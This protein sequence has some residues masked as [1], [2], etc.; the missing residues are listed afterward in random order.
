MTAYEG[1][2][3][4]FRLQ[5]K[6]LKRGTTD[7]F[8]AR[9]LETL[10]AR[11]R[12]LC[13][14][15]ALAVTA[16]NRLVA[17]WIGTGI[18]VQWENKSMQRAWDEFYSNPNLDGFGSLLNTQALWAGGVFEVG[19][20]FDRMLISNKSNATIP[21]KLQSIAPEQLD[22]KYFKL[23]KIKNSIEF[24]ATGSI[25][26]KYHFLKNHPNGRS[27]TY[28]HKRVAIKADSLLHLF[29]RSAPGQWR[30]IPKLAPA[31]L[32]IY[33]MDELTDA[34]LVRQK[35][36]QAVGWIIKKQNLGAAPLIGN[37]GE[38]TV[39]TDDSE[40]KLGTKIQK[41]LPG[42][43][44][45]LQDDEDFTFAAID[46]IGSNFISLL[47]Y[48]TRSIAGCLD[49]T[50]EQLTG[51]LSSVNFSS[52]RAGIIEFRKRVTLMQR[53]IFVNRGM[54]PLT[55]YFKELASVYI[56]K[57]ASQSRCTFVFPK[58]EEVDRLKDAQADLLEVQAG[59]ATLQDKLA[60]RG[61]PDIETHIQQI[62]NE[63]GYGVTLTSNPKHQIKQT[64]KKKE[65]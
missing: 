46:D 37:M 53:L 18:Q 52:I 33:E 11:S 14:N 34:T 58:M 45:Y 43:I 8:A 9:E 42:G 51:D 64:S 29:D 28:I 63:Q 47:D 19:E 50:Y 36:A 21:L 17:H 1:A 49:L 30:G 25:P 61:I 13:R 56:G 65:N 39:E 5:Q 7:S 3:Q 54:I 44:H 57:A 15:N 16:R 20:A 35:A 41:V 4:G 23:G 27:L 48:N 31:M 22:P 26:S 32:S 2:S 24:D 12:H 60:E 38:T 59:L 6:G 40:E 62:L 10:W 55:N